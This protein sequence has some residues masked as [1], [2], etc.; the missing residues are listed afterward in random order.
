MAPPVTAIAERMDRLS[1]PEPNTG[2][3]LWLG[4]IDRAGYGHVKDSGE[5]RKAATVAWEL[6]HGSRVPSGLVLDHRCRMR[7]CVNPD[8]LEAVTQ[9][10]NW[11]RGDGPRVIKYPKRL[12]CDCGEV[13][14]VIWNGRGVEE[15]GCRNCRARRAREWRE[16]TGFDFN[17]YRADNKDRINAQRRERRRR[18]KQ[19]ALQNERTT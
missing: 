16:K 1:I 3:Y 15:R 2:C 6:R 9:K 4:K 11:D 13:Y 18:V 19:Y 14:E 7:C 8:H 12:I 17:A 10:V 5:D